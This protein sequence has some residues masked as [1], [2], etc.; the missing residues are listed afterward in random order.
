MRV[1]VLRHVPFEGPGLIAEWAALRGYSLTESFALTEEF[2]DLDDVGLLVVMGGPMGANDDEAHPWLTAEKRYLASAVRAAST[3]DGTSGPAVL[4][5]CL[6]AQ[7][8]AVASGGSVH[9]NPLR[10]IGWYPV[11]LTGRGAADR[12]FSAFPEELVVG[13][14]HGD[15]FEL[16]EGVS[17]TLSSEACR[18]QAFSLAGGRVVGLQFHL[19]WDTDDVRLLALECADEIRVEDRWV[20]P[21]PDFVDQAERWVAPCREVLF[22]MLDAMVGPEPAEEP[23]EA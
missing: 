5:V 15:T 3:E 11:R 4:G 9:R 7:L 13:L 1:H 22:G 23:G 2:P 8:L 6:G 19:E 21:A 18:N 14:W 20:T 10:E 12:I 17:P 16:P